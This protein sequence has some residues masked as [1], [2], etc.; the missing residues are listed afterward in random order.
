MI[1]QSWKPSLRE[2][3]LRSLSCFNRAMIIQ[4]WK[5]CFTGFWEKSRHGA[6]IEPWLFNHGN[7][8][9]FSKYF[10]SSSASIEPWLFNHGNSYHWWQNMS[11][12]W[13]FNRA[14]I[15]QSWKQWKFDGDFCCKQ[16]ASIEPWLFNHGNKED[17][18]KYYYPVCSASIEPWLFNHG[19]VNFLLFQDIDVLLQ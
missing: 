13:R 18:A 7:Y 17:Y 5:R 1:I 12:E 19:N 3:T 9:F 11:I 4:S 10:S 16:F 14:M 15:I 6:S 2:G 8:S